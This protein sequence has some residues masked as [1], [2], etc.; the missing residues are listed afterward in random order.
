MPLITSRAEAIDVREQ[1]ARKLRAIIAAN[2][3]EPMLESALKQL[4]FIKGPVETGTPIRPADHDRLNFGFLG[5]RHV[6][7]FDDA[8]G[9]RLSDLA[10]YVRSHLGG[11]SG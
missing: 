3:G 8:L 10:E 4:D 5:L 7:E 9:R 6:A 11:S 1:C 2:P